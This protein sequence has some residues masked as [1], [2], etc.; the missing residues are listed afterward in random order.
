L[1]L[2]VSL[3]KKSKQKAL[4]MVNQK[5]DRVEA[6]KAHAKITKEK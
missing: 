6:A 1:P 4:V 5:N 3:Y 2:C